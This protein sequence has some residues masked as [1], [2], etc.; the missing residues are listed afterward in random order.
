MDTTGILFIDDIDLNEKV[1]FLRVDFNVPLDG[2][3]ITDETRIDA[4]LPTIRYAMENGAKLVLASHLGRPQG[5]KNK[6]LRMEVVAKRLAEILEVE[7]IVPEEIEEGIIKTLIKGLKSNQ[8][9]LLE[10]LRFNPGEKSG[11]L[12]FAKRL[13]SLA[14]VYINDAFGAVHRKHSSVYQMVEYFRRGSLGA[15]FLVKKEI[16]ELSKLGRPAHPF[17][18]VMGGAKVSDKITALENLLVDK[19]DILLIGGAMAYTFL[20]AQGK[21]VGNSLVENEQIDLAKNIIKIAKQKRKKI[22]FP[23]DHIV[24]DSIDAAQ[25]QSVETIP[26][27]KAAFDIGPKTIAIYVEH[28]AK[29]KTVFWNGP[30]GVFERD[31]FSNGT[32][33][34]AEAIASSDAFTIVGGGDSAAAVAKA[35]VGD[36]IDHVSTGGGASMEFVEGKALPGIDAL[37]PNH[38]FDHS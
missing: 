22:Y 6:H 15:G 28:I 4:A 7:V 2:K 3:E 1:V 36:R 12:E 35:G 8:I 33:K 5:K 20:K 38:P 32:M 13:A 14:D 31:I 18:A 19:V 37:R 27:D 17:V 30:M 16:E 10:N 9:I 26:A 24:A 29:A 11:D 34:I 23:V 25:A 21:A